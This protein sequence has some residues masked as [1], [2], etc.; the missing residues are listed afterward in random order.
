MTPP[1]GLLAPVNTK[2]YVIKTGEQNV[3]KVANS[4]ANALAG[5]A[6]DITSDWW[7]SI[8][9]RANIDPKYYF[10]VS[11]PQGPIPFR[12]FTGAKN[13]RWKNFSPKRIGNGFFHIR[14]SM[15]GFMIENFAAENVMRFIEEVTDQSPG[16]IINGVI[17]NGSVVKYSETVWRIHYSTNTCVV[18]NVF[19]DS[20]RQDGDGFAVGWQ[21]QGSARDLAFV[22]VESN[23]NHD[24]INNAPYTANPNPYW[25]SDGFSTERGNTRVL[26]G[27]LHRA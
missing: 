18:R 15:T 4:L 17:R 9:L 7:S 21:V 8:G 10:K 19:N 2:F 6:I 5:T 1:G 23:R 25:N 16:S 22:D 11:R 14:A 20:C 27:E 3:I 12:F 13:L 24:E 26:L